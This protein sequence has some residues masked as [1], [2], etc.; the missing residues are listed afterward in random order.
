MLSWFH[1]LIL[2]ITIA[3]T[4][5]YIPTFRRIKLIPYPKTSTSE[6]I[7]DEVTSLLMVDTSWGMIDPMVVLT[8]EKTTVET[9]IPMSQSD[10]DERINVKQN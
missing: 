8:Q 1:L 7:Y 2:I 5:K 4:V 9:H 3:G 10:I 6:S